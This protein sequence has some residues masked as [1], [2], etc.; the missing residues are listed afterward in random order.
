MNTD[1]RRYDLAALGLAP[2]PVSPAAVAVCAAWDVAD[3]VWAV[4]IAAAR[5]PLV[6]GLAVLDVVEGRAR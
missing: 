5:L 4:W 3:A 2:P 1:T 6:A